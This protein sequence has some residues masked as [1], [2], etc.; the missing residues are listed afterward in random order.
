MLANLPTWLRAAVITSVQAFVG[1]F[2]VTLLGLLGDIQ[3]WVEDSTNP[4]DLGVPAKAI[5]SA[6]VALAVGVVTAVFRAVKPVENSYPEPP[7]P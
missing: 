1:T 4:V 6:V 5:G 7:K 2:L 3:E